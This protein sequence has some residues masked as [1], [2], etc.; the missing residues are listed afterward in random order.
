VDLTD[1]DRVN[2]DR[3]LE[4]LLARADELAG[5]ERPLYDL[6]LRRACGHHLASRK[7]TAKVGD[8][9][10]STGVATL[11]AWASCLTLGDLQAAIRAEAA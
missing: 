7:G 8:T 4:T 6:L 2:L 1:E 9:V 5:Q 3:T 11:D 10:T